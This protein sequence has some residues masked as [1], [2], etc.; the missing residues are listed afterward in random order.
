[1]IEIL[2][3]QGYDAFSKKFYG[4]TVSEELVW[5]KACRKFLAEEISK[6]AVTKIWILIGV[7]SILKSIE[8]RLE[9][10]PSL[11]VCLSGSQLEIWSMILN[12]LKM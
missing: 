10:V 4:D 3:Q 5:N 8:E 1:M 7:F 6:V 12:I 11:W 2:E 9:E